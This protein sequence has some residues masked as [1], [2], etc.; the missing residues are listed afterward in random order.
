MIGLRLLKEVI[1]AFE[2]E[3]DTKRKTLVQ[4]CESTYPLLENIMAS[5]M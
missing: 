4:V 5:V 1:R 3:I 2:Y